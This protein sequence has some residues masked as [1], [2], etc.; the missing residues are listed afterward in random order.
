MSFSETDKLVQR[1]LDGEL[2]GS[3][4]AA[5]A[6]RMLSDSTL[7]KRVEG[8]QQ[9]QSCFAAEASSMRRDAQPSAGF[10]AA[11]ISEVRRLP[12]RV[13]LQQDDLA[14]SA[15]RL[16]SRLLLAAALL[17]GLGLGLQAGLFDPNGSGQIEAASP[18][19]VDAE[20]QRLDGLARDAREREVTD[21]APRETPRRGR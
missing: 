4:G 7:R 11:V 3:E 12:S 21:R 18:T 15:V 16:C 8:A 9:I 6:A 10:T 19:E 14:K 20:M 17:I 13:E 1:F 2:S 5:F